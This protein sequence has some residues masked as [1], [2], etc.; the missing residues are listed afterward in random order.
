MKDTSKDIILVSIIIIENYYL[1]F[2]MVYYYLQ[3]NIYDSHW[4]TY[5]PM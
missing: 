4:K 1:F 5:K 3:P 2:Q